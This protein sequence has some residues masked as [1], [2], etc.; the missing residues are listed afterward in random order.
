MYCLCLLWSLLYVADDSNASHLTVVA[1]AELSS[2]NLLYKNKIKT[3]QF[4]L[5]DPL[6]VKW[7]IQACILLDSPQIPQF[8]VTHVCT[9]LRHSINATKHCLWPVIYTTII[10]KTVTCAT[11]HGRRPQVSLLTFLQD[12]ISTVVAMNV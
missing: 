6:T 11:N 7:K 10:G 2:L 12:L 3:V 8:S 4:L 5:H 9:D 1:K